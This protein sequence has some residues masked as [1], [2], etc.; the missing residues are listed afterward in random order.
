MMTEE[1]HLDYVIVQR[2]Y[3]QYSWK[4][5]SFDDEYYLAQFFI[6]FCVVHENANIEELMIICDLNNLSFIHDKDFILFMYNKAS[7]YLDH[8]VERN[9]ISEMTRDNY[10]GWLDKMKMKLWSLWSSK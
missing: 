5:N 2:I 6:S 1:E 4:D 9:V 7:Q 8:S 3:E 10:M